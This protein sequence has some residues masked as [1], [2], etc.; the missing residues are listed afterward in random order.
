MTVQSGSEYGDGIWELKIIPLSSALTKLF[1]G[2][3]VGQF[4]TDLSLAD[5]YTWEVTDP[6]G[7]VTKFL[8]VE[9]KPDILSQN[10]DPTPGFFIE[11]FCTHNAAKCPD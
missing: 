7:S 10:F 6:Q 1:T 5:T 2:S 9:I 3:S 8:T 4:T 11:E